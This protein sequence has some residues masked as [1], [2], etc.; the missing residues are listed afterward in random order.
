MDEE[1]SLIHSIRNFLCNTQGQRKISD[2]GGNRTPNLR[3]KSPL[4]YRVLLS[5]FEFFPIFLNR[6]RLQIKYALFTLPTMIYHRRQTTTSGTTCPTLCNKCAG[7]FT[8]H[9]IMNI[10]GLLD[11]TSGFS[12][13][14]EKTRES[15]H[16]RVHA[17]LI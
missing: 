12:S 16:L 10:E 11:G 15:N 5:S 2:L 14:S 1:P 13:L 17:H 8:S 7:S 9:R 3:I 4:L 6:A